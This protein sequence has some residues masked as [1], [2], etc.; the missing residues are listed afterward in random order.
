MIYYA[1]FD[2]GFVSKITAKNVEQA[3][4]YYDQ[5]AI[6]EEAGILLT[7]KEAEKVAKAILKI[8]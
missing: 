4:D 7:K 3:N 2:S 1:I 6:D 8:K 5:V